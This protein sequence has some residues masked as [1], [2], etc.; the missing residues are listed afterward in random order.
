MDINN[1]VAAL[2]ER[3][4]KEERSICDHELVFFD[5][6]GH[7]FKQSED[8]FGRTVWTIL[9]NQNNAWGWYFVDSPHVS[10]CRSN[11]DGSELTRPTE[12]DEKKYHNYAI[13]SKYLSYYIN[14]SNQMMLFFYTLKD[15]LLGFTTL[16]PFPT[17]QNIC[18]ITYTESLERDLYDQAV[19]MK[20]LPYINPQSFEQNCSMDEWN[21]KHNIDS[22]SREEE[23]RCDS[24]GNWYTKQEFYEYYGSYIQWGFQHPLNINRRILLIEG[25]REVTNPVTLNCLIDKLVSI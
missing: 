11:D 4:S 13:D 23:Y 25:I 18:H 12:P 21:V 22:E 8:Q 10:T 17:W 24:N 9:S 15:G 7:I 20:E 5:K 2:T 14:E 19:P 16:H 3:F 6:S 1:K